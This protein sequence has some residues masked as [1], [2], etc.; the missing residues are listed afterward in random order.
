MYH[1]SSRKISRLGHEI[2][3]HYDDVETT[4]W[5]IKRKNLRQKIKEEQLIDRAYES[6]VRNLEKM[7]TIT[8]IKT[9]CM[10]GSP[11]SKYDNRLIWQ[12]YNYRDL[13]IVGEPYYDIDWENTAYFTDTGR[14]WNGYSVSVRDKVNS[15]H[16]FDFKTTPEIIA[17]L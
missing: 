7:R 6:F 14:R 12:K 8:D 16:S 15:K 5:A 9:I 4:F 13:G 1:Q 2:G 3:Y 10:H 11:L 17:N